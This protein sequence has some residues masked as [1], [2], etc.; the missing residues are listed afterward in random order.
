[1][2]ATSA[3]PVGAP[4]A[5]IPLGPAELRRRSLSNML[6]EGHCAPTVMK[7]LAEA[8]GTADAPR[9]V[10]LATGL[11]GIGNTGHECGAITAPLV[12]LG[13]RHAREPL[14]DGVPVAVS[15]GRALMHDFRARHGS[16]ACRDILVLK[17]LPL[18]CVGVVRHGAERCADV[19][20]RRGEQ[21]LTAEERRA[22][23]RLHAHLVASG[24]HCAH[25]VLQRSHGADAVDADLLDATSAFV[26][27]T[28]Y[29]GL[30]CSALTA[31]V[32]LLG[33]AHG[34]AEHAPRRVLRTVAGMALGGHAFAEDLEAVNRP[35]YEGHA[36]ARWFRRELG[37]TQCRKI[38]FCDFATE[39]G[40]AKYVESGCVIRC[41]EIARAVAERARGMIE[42]A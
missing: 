38:T 26:G 17:R 19:D 40:A 27:G 6:R 25:A 15:K 37:S 12:V 28:A 42:R 18:R 8:I 29:A 32:M 3:V 24:F 21:A 7:T 33:L 4:P 9:L 5:P 14:E 1:M 10:R 39:A 31:G 2:T 23:A 16:C 20:A 13:L 34:H 41:R 36:L 11:P 22:C 30:T 35:I